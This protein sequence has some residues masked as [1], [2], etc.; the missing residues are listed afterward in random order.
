MHVTPHAVVNAFVIGL[1]LG[2]LAWRT[3]SVWPGIVSHAFI[4]GIWNIWQ[5]GKILQIFPPTPSLAVTTAI[6][7]VALACFFA[8]IWLLV[9]PRID[10]T[11]PALA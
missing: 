10:A 6:F 3:G 11:Q 8:S 4:N 1:W 2:A 9:R 5:I 7:T